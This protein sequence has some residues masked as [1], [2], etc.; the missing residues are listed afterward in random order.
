MA[1][2]QMGT[3]RSLQKEEQ[4]ILEKESKGKNR[5]EKVKRD[6]AFKEEMKYST[7]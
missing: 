1:S 7:R 2:L 4:N 6:E 3:M 5:E